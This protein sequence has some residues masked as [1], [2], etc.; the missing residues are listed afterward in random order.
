MTLIVALGFCGSIFAQ[1]YESHWP[2]FYGPAFE[3]QTPFVA[4]FQI[5]GQ[6]IT[7]DYEGWNALEIAFFV[8]DEC[9]GSG[10]TF[11]NSVPFTYYLYNGYVE[12]Y[13]DPFPVIDGAALYYTDGGEEVTVKVY[14]HLREI[15]YTDCVVTLAGEPYTILTG[16]DNDQGWYDPENPIMLSFTSPAPPTPETH[17]WDD[18]NTW[19]SGSVPDSLAPVTLTNNVIIGANDTVYA[20]NVNLNGFTLTME[21]G[22]QFYHTNA[23]DMTIQMNVDGYQDTRDENPDNDGYRLIASP[24]YAS[25]TNP[26]SIDI[27]EAMLE[28]NYDLYYFDQTQDLEWINHKLGNDQYQ[29]TTLDLGKGYLY[30]NTEDVFVV[31]AGQTLPT[32]IPMPVSLTYEEN[33]HFPGWNL[34]GNPYTAKAYADRAYYVLDAEGDEVISAE[35]GEGI[36]PM[37]G[38][39]VE[40]GSAEDLTCTVSTTPQNNNT[41]SLNINLSQANT[42]ADRAIVSFGSG[43]TLS[44]FQLN[45]KHTK[46]YISQEG[47]D[48][49]VVSAS[50]KGEMPVSFKAEKNGNYT[51]SF[52][53]KEVTFSYLRLIDNM[54]GV[55]TDLLETPN[56][57]FNARTTDY[58]NRFKLVFATGSNNDSDNFAFFNNGNLVINNEGQATLQ[59]VDVMGRILRSESINGCASISVKAAPG[60]YML[61]LINGN[62]VKVQKVIIK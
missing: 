31:F 13:G 11:H 19:E 8:G 48:Y 46:V 3:S 40:A 44:K 35:L 53:N 16:A 58:A 24:V 49:A 9:R 47:K 43:M 28:G 62:D 32:S 15:E 51:L 29:F 30:A 60:V 39:F 20:G 4:A 54:T 25:N 27:P 38:F 61:R 2:D 50:D 22:A 37:K 57:T 34:V 18:P 21:P 6:I 52:T 42:L 36:A 1:N 45:P 26:A 55:E 17:Y 12:E 41:G 33:A 14:D 59:V 23:I 56:Y 7:A 5:D 10:S